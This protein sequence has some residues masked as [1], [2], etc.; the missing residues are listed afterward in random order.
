MRVSDLIYDPRLLVG[1]QEQLAPDVQHG[2]V[3]LRQPHGPNLHVGIVVDRPDLLRNPNQELM[4][5]MFEQV[6]KMGGNPIHIEIRMN[7]I[8]RVYEDGKP[9]PLLTERIP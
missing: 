5:D 2:F 4:S 1:L 6:R 9:K 7:G 3:S 8:R